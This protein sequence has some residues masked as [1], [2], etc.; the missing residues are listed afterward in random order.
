MLHCLMDK[1]VPSIGNGLK[2]CPYIIEITKEGRLILEWFGEEHLDELEKLCG[3]RTPIGPSQF[4]GYPQSM[5][6][7]R[8]FDR[9][10]NNTC[11]VLP[12]SPTGRKD[13]RLKRGNILFS[14]RSLGVI[15]AIEKESGEIVWA[16]GPGE[17]DGQH[18][19][20]MLQNGN[21]STTTEP[22]ANGLVS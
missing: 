12:D 10:H 21:M 2:R 11:E 8:L 19:P 16:R 14:Y 4:R 20:T 6:D 22:D 15:G 9:A 7:S 3:I 18:Q 17:L 13:S 5:M 1:M